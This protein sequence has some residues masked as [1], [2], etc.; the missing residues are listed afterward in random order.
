MKKVIAMGLALVAFGL[1]VYLVRQGALGGRRTVSIEI[2][3]TDGYRLLV[4]K[5]PFLVRGV[6]YS[7][8]PIGKDYEYN[9]WGDPN[10]PWLADGK[11]MKD[12]GVNTVRFYRMGKNPEEAREVVGDLYRKYGIHSLVGHYLGFWGWP[13][14][15]Y[16]DEAF[17]EKI[18]TQVMEMVRLY[19]DTPGVL[20]WVLGNENNYSFDRNVQ[21]W[22][23]DAIDA[24]PTPEAQKAE[25]AKLYYSFVNALAR[26]IKTMDPLHPVVM[27]VGETASLAAAAEHCPD[28]DAIGMIAYRGPGFGNLFRQVKQQFDRP[29]LLTE[30]GAD[31]YNAQVGAPDEESQAQFLKL[32]WKDIE[33]NSD[34]KKG[35]GNCLGGTLFEWSDEWWKGNEN[36]PHT[37]S[38]QD[39]AGHWGNA[40]YYTD[41]EAIGRMNMNEE[42]WGI[43]ALDPKT[44]ADGNNARLPKKAYFVLKSLWTQSS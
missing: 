41:A 2:Q 23:S 16:A 38:V 19:K 40:S 33:R 29:V 26:E 14:P 20:M 24:L 9:F 21:R 18:R 36:L 42:W 17:K 35:E 43:V 6:C 30:W 10:K 28:I 39:T 15:N 4:D 3:K 13:P 22:S 5:K 12:A 8:V 32:Q 1:A 7:P 31:S 34:P 27:S 25:K 37:W 44:S 11:M